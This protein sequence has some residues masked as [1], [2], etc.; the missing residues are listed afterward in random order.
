MTTK[1]AIVR[2][3]MLPTEPTL[4][5]LIA[6]GLTELQTLED[7]WISNMREVSC[8]PVGRYPV[9]IDRSNRFQRLMPHVLEVPNRDG[10]RIHSGNTEADTTGCVLVGLGRDGDCVTAS[11]RAFGL[12]MNWLAETL[13][14]GE[15]FVEISV[16]EG[17]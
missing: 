2:D 13:K 8:I 6:Q 7:P 12:F 10:I 5:R 11:R 9:V 16:G 4:G 17:A 3:A 14:V 1:F 15:V